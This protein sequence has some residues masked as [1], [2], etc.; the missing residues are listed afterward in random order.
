[1]KRL[2][3]YLLLASLLS[4]AFFDGSLDASNQTPWN[5]VTSYVC[6]Y[7]KFDPRMANFDVAILE[8]DSLTKEQIQSLKKQGTYTIGYLSIGEDDSLNK[9]D[10]KGPGG[11]A[12]YYFDDGKGHP[13]QNGNWNS[14]YTNAANALWQDVIVYQRAKQILI[15]KG[16]DGLFLDTLDTVDLYRDTRDGMVGLVKKLRDTYPDKKLVINRGFTVLPNVAQ[17]LDGLMF[18]D[19][20]STYDF[21]TKKYAEASPED[22]NTNLMLVV[23]TVNQL[24]KEHYFV[25]FGLDYALSTDKSLIQQYYDTF[26]EYDMIPYVSTIDLGKVYLHDIKPRTVRGS[27]AHETI[28]TQAEIDRSKALPDPSTDKNNY[29][30][31]ANGAIV[32]VDSTFPGYGI[33]ALNDG[34]RNEPKLSWADIAWASGETVDEHWVKLTFGDVQTISNVKIIWALDANTYWSSQQVVLQKFVDGKWMDM[35]DVNAIPQWQEITDIQFDQQTVKELRI[36][37]PKGMGPTKRPDLMWISE[38]EVH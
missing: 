15:D 14:Y 3:I 35:V 20:S 22:K 36:L 26:W 19:F 6:Y 11:Y 2:N 31:A 24:K 12:S 38:V 5:Q 1:M 32:T 16:C 21:E 23:N 29:A 28:G 17:Y 33:K 37:Q 34:Y 27:K 25:T 13:A 9:G 8:P 7:G 4:L 30:L 18:E 10:G